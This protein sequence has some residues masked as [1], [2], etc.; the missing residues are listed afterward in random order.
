MVAAIN[1]ILVP[2]VDNFLMLLSILSMPI[3]LKANTAF[4]H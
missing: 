2:V 3:C 1:N 4:P